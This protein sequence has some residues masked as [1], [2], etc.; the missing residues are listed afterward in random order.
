MR[1]SIFRKGFLIKDSICG[2]ENNISLYMTYKVITIILISNEYYQF[3]TQCKFI[4]TNFIEKVY[5]CF[6][7]KDMEIQ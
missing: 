5:I 6:I 1:V 3:R 2:M 4:G 7:I